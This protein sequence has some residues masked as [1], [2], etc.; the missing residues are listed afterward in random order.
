[1][2]DPVAIV[3]V[4]VFYHKSK[5]SKINRFLNK[6]QAP[7]GLLDNPG[8]RK[9]KAFKLVGNGDHVLMYSWDE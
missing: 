2:I 9:F 5:Q 8:P 4:Q 3:N 7:A 1:M 6:H